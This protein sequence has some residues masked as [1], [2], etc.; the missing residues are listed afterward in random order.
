MLIVNRAGYNFSWLE[1]RKMP[2]SKL[3]KYHA[4]AEE[5]FRQ[6]KEAMKRSSSDNTD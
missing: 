3:L 6:E 1:M 2:K 4:I 5:F